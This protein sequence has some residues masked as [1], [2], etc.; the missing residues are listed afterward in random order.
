MFET[1]WIYTNEGVKV[2]EFKVS[3]IGLLSGFM[4]EEEFVK[5]RFQRACEHQGLDPADH[6]YCIAAA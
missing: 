5:A 6:N 2:G 1:Y 3:V 4:T